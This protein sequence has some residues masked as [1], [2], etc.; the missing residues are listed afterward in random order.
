MLLGKPSEEKTPANLSL[1]SKAN[2]SLA[3]AFVHNGRVKKAVVADSERT[4]AGPVQCSGTTRDIVIK[5]APSL[6]ISSLGHCAV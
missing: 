2:L 1:P 4:C 3:Q 6:R 5:T